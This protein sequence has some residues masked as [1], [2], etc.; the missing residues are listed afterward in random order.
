MAK[1]AYIGTTIKEMTN[2]FYCC[3]VP[4]LCPHYVKGGGCSYA[5]RTPRGYFVAITES[6][7]TCCRSKGKSSDI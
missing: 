2:A 1:V 3:I 5:D 6:Y 4:D 7:K